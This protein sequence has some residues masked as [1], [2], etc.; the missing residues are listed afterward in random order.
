MVDGTHSGGGAARR[1]RSVCHVAGFRECVLL[2]GAV[3]FAVLFTADRSAASLV[4]VFSGAV[5]FGGP[6]GIPGDLLLL[7]KGLL[8]RVFSRSTRLRCGRACQPAIQRRNEIS[9]HSTKPTPLLSVFGHPV[10]GFFVARRSAGLSLRRTLWYWTWHAGLAAERHVA[11]D[12]HALVPFVAA[13][14]R[15]KIGL[16]FVRNVR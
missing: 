12:L 1:L 7:P 5:D 8:P 13:S 10:S 16:L 6:A 11:F 15:R 9:V 3:S 2:V 14:G 4:A